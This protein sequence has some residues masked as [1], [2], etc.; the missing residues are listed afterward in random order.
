MADA[1]TW[2]GIHDIDQF[3]NARFT[4]TNNMSRHTFGNRYQFIVNYQHA[5]VEAGDETFRQYKT[6]PALFPGEM[7]SLAYLLV[8]G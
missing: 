1:T 2:I 4:I 8:G 3:C 6:R 5:M 7:K